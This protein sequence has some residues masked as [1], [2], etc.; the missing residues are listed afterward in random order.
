MQIACTKDTI[1]MQQ[2]P[3]MFK[4]SKDG[5]SVLTTL[6]SRRA[7]ADGKYPVKVQVVYNRQ[8]KYYSTGKN[9]T[10]EEWE[11]LPH[12]KVRALADIRTDIEN[13]FNIV[14]DNVES[15][16]YTGEFSFDA[17]NQRL[18]RGSNGTVNAAFQAKI[19]DL[20][21]NERIGNMMVYDTILKGIERFSGSNI[22]FHEITTDWLKRY[23]KFLLGEQKSYTTIG[24]HMRTL[25]AILNNARKVG[26][27]KESAYPFG[28]DRYEIKT[29]EGR[30]KA[31]TMEQIG[32]IARY[33]DGGDATA[34]YRDYWLFLYLCNG[35]NMADFVK[36][37]YSNI[38]NGEIFF[39]RQK[40]EHTTR[41]RKE[42]RVVITEP[43]QAIID[44]WGNPT[45][46]DNYIFPVLTGKE[47]ALTQKHKT[48]YL[49][50]AINK[51][52]A[53]IGE[54]LGMGNISTYTARHSFA[55]VLKRSG[56]NIAFISESLGHN[57]LKTTENYLASFE[58]EER[59][60]N[61]ELL[62]QF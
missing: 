30:K 13:S 49:T 12:T 19:A 38:D 51:R 31:L 27:I 45:S 23:E 43:M 1:C 9:M 39:V 36:L 21:S 35:I 14:R 50:R 22:Q 41:T 15:I 28:R 26:I 32:Q 56:A 24:I 52:M 46:P 25:R 29:T 17:L 34:K 47:D 57:D 40:T 11:K 18:K 16:A 7:K 6:D 54:V 53:A 10:S 42:I 48:Q 4:Y 20:R 61:A 59:V 3:I 8:Q 55:T 62:T 33:E 2:Q 37:K 60:K 44:R 5:I 58:R